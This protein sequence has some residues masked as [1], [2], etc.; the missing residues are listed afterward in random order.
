MANA[1]TK[2]MKATLKTISTDK[3][4]QARWF[5]LIRLGRAGRKE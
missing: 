2:K 4:S 3:E 5:Y 1:A